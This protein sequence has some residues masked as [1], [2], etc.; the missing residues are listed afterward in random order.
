MYLTGATLKHIVR[1]VGEGIKAA[2]KAK[3][4]TRSELRKAMARYLAVAQAEGGEDGEPV[5]DE[6]NDDSVPCIQT[7]GAWELGTRNMTLSRFILICAVLDVSAFEVLRHALP[8]VAVP[9][10]AIEVDRRKLACCDTEDLVPL[11]R[12]L[13]ATDHRRPLV[14]LGRVQDVVVLPPD[15]LASLATLLGCPPSNLPRA[16]CTPLPPI[17]VDLC[18]TCPSSPALSRTC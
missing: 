14:D 6:A 16:H 18:P 5:A 11:K 15:S 4:W 7:L 10:G 12:W 3:G 8:S 17:G 1:E 2:R 9:D 13:E